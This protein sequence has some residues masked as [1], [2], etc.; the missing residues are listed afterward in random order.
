MSHWTTDP[1]EP[2][3]GNEST[4]RQQ[5]LAYL[6]RRDYSQQELL[7]RLQR[8][9]FASEQVKPVLAALIASGLQSDERFV[10]AKVRQWQAAGKGPAYILHALLQR[11]ISSE[12]CQAALVDFDWQKGI[13]QQVAKRQVL[14]QDAKSQAKLMR[15]LA[16]RGYSFDQIRWALAEFREY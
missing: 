2:S 5:L 7:Q 10:E 15:W 3:Q 16:G 9:G 14:L 13:L 1:S 11:G 12:L 4:I 6:Q 8:K